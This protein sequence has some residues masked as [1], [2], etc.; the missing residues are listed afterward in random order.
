MPDSDENKTSQPWHVRLL[1]GAIS[2]IA[3]YF[4]IGWFFSELQFVTHQVRLAIAFGVFVCGW[5]FYEQMW[6][7]LFWF[8]YRA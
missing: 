8:K 2:G 1:V 4:L 7:I 6:D 5:A 3:A